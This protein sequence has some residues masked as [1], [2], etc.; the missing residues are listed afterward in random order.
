MGGFSSDSA[1][2]GG[3]ASIRTATVTGIRKEATLGSECLADSESRGCKNQSGEERLTRFQLEAV[4]LDCESS[5]WHSKSDK[6]A[7]AEHTVDAKEAMCASYAESSSMPDYPLG[8]ECKEGFHE[9]L[10]EIENFS[11]ELFESILS[12]AM[13]AAAQTD[14]MIAALG[15]GWLSR[16]VSQRSRLAI[17]IAADVCSVASKMCRLGVDGAK[18][19]KLTD[20][21]LALVA[22]TSYLGEVD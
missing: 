10:A 2:H 3:S 17:E 1:P 18:V 20:S 13:D 9:N 14:P 19:Q 7:P 8:A 5:R 16:G 15:P 11:I 21:L 4:A 22:G 6:A 12:D